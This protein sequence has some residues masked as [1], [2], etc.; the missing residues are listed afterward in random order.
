MIVARSVIAYDK[1]LPKKPGRLPWLKPD[2]HLVKDGKA[3]TGW[4]VADWRGWL[5]GRCVNT[6]NFI[7]FT[8]TFGRHRLPKHSID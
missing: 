5:L 3:E 4:R 1:D 7:R 2:A 8:R 6:D